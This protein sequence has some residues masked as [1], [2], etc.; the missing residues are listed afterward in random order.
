MKRIF[1]HIGAHKTATTTIQRV[2]MNAPCVKSRHGESILTLSIHNP[3]HD[4]KAFRLPFT[5]LRNR[6]M[7]VKVSGRPINPNLI[8]EMAHLVSEF[9]GTLPEQHIVWSDENLLGNTPGH[10]TGPIR[11]FP[12]GF[13]PASAP[14]AEAFHM[15]L[16]DHQTSVRLYTRASE[17]LIR[18]AYN[19]WISKLRTPTDYAE[20]SDAVAQGDLSWESVAAPWQAKFGTA[21]DMC[22]FETVR[23]GQ[24]AFLQAFADWAELSVE[25]PAALD[26]APPANQSFTAR[27]VKMARMIMPHVAPEERP[28]LR[29]FLAQLR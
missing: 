18:S 17:G 29:R 4:Y 2:L 27:Q 13:Y 14:I 7:A 22:R 20:F 15:A 28:A 24:G 23:D 11:D 21:F 3:M 12:A 10:P 19:D 26:A 6:M 8:S 9:V 5:H 16:A 25:D 1:L